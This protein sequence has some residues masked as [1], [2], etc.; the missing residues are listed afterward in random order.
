M[1]EP[2]TPLVPSKTLS[3]A[4]LRGIAEVVSEL[5]ATRDDT[6]DARRTGMAFTRA[7]LRDP[8]FKARV[9]EAHWRLL[10]SRARGIPR[11]R[12]EPFAP[13]IKDLEAE[14]ER[15]LGRSGLSNAQAFLS[16]AHKTSWRRRP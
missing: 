13:L 2:Y 11:D 9:A 15:I 8:A 5:A 4:E 1:R 3:E 6:F 10:A 7:A 16:S 14:A 12:V